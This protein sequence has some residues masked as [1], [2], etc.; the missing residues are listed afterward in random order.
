VEILLLCLQFCVLCGRLELLWSLQA[1]D[2]KGWLNGLPRQRYSGSSFLLSGPFHGFL[3]M[4]PP[5]V[6]PR[7]NVKSE[8]GLDQKTDT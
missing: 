5:A 3:G 8:A 6:S 1:Q 4:F 2:F 7:K